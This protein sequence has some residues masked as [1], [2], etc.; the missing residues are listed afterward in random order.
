M[1]FFIRGFK[2]GARRAVKFPLCVFV[3]CISTLQDS[4]VSIFDCLSGLISDSL[5]C[6]RSNFGDYP[7]TAG[8]QEDGWG[9]F[10]F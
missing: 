8:K 9:L 2:M 10:A 4:S 7:I 3:V 1:S 6:A 5:L